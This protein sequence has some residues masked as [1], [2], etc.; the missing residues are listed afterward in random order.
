MG[1]VIKAGSRRRWNRRKKLNGLKSHISWRG[2]KQ[3]LSDSVGNKSCYQ[4]AECFNLRFQFKVL[5]RTCILVWIQRW[6]AKIEERNDITGK[7]V[8]KR[9]YGVI[10]DIYLGTWFTSNYG[11]TWGEGKNT[12]SHILNTLEKSWR[13]FQFKTVDWTYTSISLPSETPLDWL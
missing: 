5:T 6:V 3:V 11:N 4:K 9:M 10:C 13:N 8:G 7:V 1:C 2:Q 12:L